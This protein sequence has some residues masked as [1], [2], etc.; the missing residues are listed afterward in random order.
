MVQCTCL[1]ITL[2]I[3]ITFSPLS[4]NTDIKELMEYSLSVI[5]YNMK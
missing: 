3:L 2:S 1:R 4:L 5:L